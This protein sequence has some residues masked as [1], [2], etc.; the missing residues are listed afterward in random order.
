[1]GALGPARG[2]AAAPQ[3]GGGVAMVESRSAASGEKEEM[4]GDKREVEDGCTCGLT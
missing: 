3:W 1:V 4:G 2:S